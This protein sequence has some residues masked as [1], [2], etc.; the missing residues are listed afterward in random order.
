MKYIIQSVEE[1]ANHAG[2]KAKADIRDIFVKNGYQQKTFI[3]PSDKLGKMMHLSN[4]IRKTLSEISVDDTI[5][6]QFP[7]GFQMKGMFDKY[8]VSCLKKINNKVV[9]VHDL[10]GL[11]QGNLYK[12][13]TEIN[14]LNQFQLVVMHNSHMTQICRKNGLTSK[15]MEIDIFDYLVADEIHDLSEV[16]QKKVNFA[17]NLEKSEFI[18]KIDSLQLKSAELNLFGPSMRKEFGQGVVYQG[19]IPSD[20][21]PSVL[22]KNGGFGL[23]WDGN[24]L[25]SCEGKNGEYLKYNNPHKLSLYIA[26]K[27]PVICWDKA[28][29]ADF[30]SNNNIGILVSSLSEID[31]KLSRLSAEE[32]DIMKSNISSIS[33][34]VK[35]GFFTKRIIEEI[36]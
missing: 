1:K 9:I 27:I 5:V 12:L 8:L 18:S 16:N 14:F 28:A 36:C 23:I 11:R 20:E 7:T 24:S 2:P 33:E 22:N 13:K 3:F 15:V 26:S 21:I 4:I 31:D 29:V 17:G 19:S 25:G 35:G 30:I 32:Y 6:L 10:E 34:K